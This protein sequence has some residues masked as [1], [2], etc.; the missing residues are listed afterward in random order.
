MSRRRTSSINILNFIGTT[1]LRTSRPLSITSMLPRLG[2][3]GLQASTA[4]Y[5]VPSVSYAIRGHSRSVISDALCASW[6]SP[7][8]SSLTASQLRQAHIIAL[9]GHP[10]RPSTAIYGQ[11][12]G[13]EQKKASLGRGGF[14]LSVVILPPA[15][16]MPA[17][18]LRLSC[19]HYIAMR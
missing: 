18:P 7:S 10:V 9:T 6:L 17:Q 19:L 15:L 4:T 1:S 8:K 3:G 12:P 11:V 16:S 2:V 14:A 13:P 5:F